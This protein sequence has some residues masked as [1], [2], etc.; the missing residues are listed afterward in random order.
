MVQNT[1]FARLNETEILI[2]GGF[3]RGHGYHHCSFVVNTHEETVK[4]IECEILSDFR[5]QCVANQSY[6]VNDNEVSALVSD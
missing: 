4:E 3:L 5:F 2:S 1:I 6:S